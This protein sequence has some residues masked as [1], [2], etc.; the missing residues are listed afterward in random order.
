MIDLA[1]YTDDVASMDAFPQGKTFRLAYDHV[2]NQMRIIA[3][4]RDQL[5]ELRKA[6]SV[7]NK[8]AFFS[9]QY[10]YRGEERLYNVNQFGYFH[11]GL[12]QKVLGW[13]RT[14]YGSLDCVAVSKRCAAYVS[15]VLMPLKAFAAEHGEFPVANV[16]DDSGRNAE[17]RLA[18]KQPFEFRDYQEESVRRLLFSSF[19][20]GLV[21][22]PTGGGKSFILA[23]LIWTLTKNVSR[24]MRF[25]ILVPNVQ[26]VEQFCKDLVDYGFDRRDLAKFEGGMSKREKTENDV[27]KARVV[28]AN[29]QYVFKNAKALP[30]FD[31]LICDEV[32]QMLAKASQDLVSRSRA[33]YKFG[34]SGTLPKDRYQLNQLIGMFGPVA[35]QEEITELQRRGFISKL[36]ITSLSVVDS[37]VEGNRDLLFHVNSTKR[38]VQDD[39][40]EDG[41][42]FDDAVKA[43]R[44]YVAKWYKELYRPVLDYVA[45]NLVGNTL[46]LFD[47]L[48]VGRSIYD[49]F[50]E[51]YPDRKAFYNDGSTK[52]SEREEVRSGL[53]DSGDNVLFAN[54]QIMSTGLNV[55][56]LHNVVFAFS[57]MSLKLI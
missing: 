37:N 32:H 11:P 24:S 52:V 48:D 8:S 44:E 39:A 13:I 56:R 36:R 41:I 57:S 46:I 6:F 26:L 50:R 55:K 19:G 10:G 34:C 25:M 45:A 54:V 31:C 51:L 2:V 4:T 17:L 23:N 43:E 21:E 35:L 20:R 16:A 14:Q 40:S 38:Y 33:L 53:E 18:G 30:E 1:Q 42:R 7:E 12:T 15:E 22:V 47:K 9:R 3:R 5:E 28:I 49:Y 27:S 29:R